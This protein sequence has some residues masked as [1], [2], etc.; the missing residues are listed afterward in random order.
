MSLLS[1]SPRPAI[2]AAGS[3]DDLTV[4]ATTKPPE[5]VRIE[6]HRK[7]TRA[8]LLC[9]DL[10]LAAHRRR[11][12]LRSHGRADG[13]VGGRATGLPRCRKCPGS[14]RSRYYR[15]ILV[16]RGGDCRL[17]SRGLAQDCPGDRTEG[18]VFQLPTAGSASGESVWETGHLSREKQI[19]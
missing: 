1:K 8:S 14:R 19:S 12:R 6:Q 5:Y 3:V 7:D 9:G 11:P 18:V 15:V 17:E 10:Y 4:R 16:E 13:A 2:L